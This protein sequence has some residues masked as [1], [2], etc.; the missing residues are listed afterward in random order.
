LHANEIVKI[1]DYAFGNCL[2]EHTFNYI[3]EGT[4]HTRGA[5]LICD[6]IKEIKVWMVLVALPQAGKADLL[7]AVQAQTLPQ[8]IRYPTAGVQTIR[9]DKDFIYNNKTLFD[10]KVQVVRPKQFRAMPDDLKPLLRP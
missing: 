5:P 9:P 6:P 1:A 3:W 2:P 8:S 7:N 10:Q 4:K